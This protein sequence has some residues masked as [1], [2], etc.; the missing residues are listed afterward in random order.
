MLSHPLSLIINFKNLKEKKKAGHKRLLRGGSFTSSSTR[1]SLSSPFPPLPLTPL[2]LDRRC[3]LDPR[4]VVY[5][6]PGALG[7]PQAFVTI[8]ELTSPS[9]TLVTSADLSGSPGCCVTPPRA[10]VTS[11]L[12]FASPKLNRYSLKVLSPSPVPFSVSGFPSQE[13][14][15]LA[16]SLSVPFLYMSSITRSL[17][18]PFLCCDWSRSVLLPR[19]SE[20]PSSPP[21]HTVIASQHGLAISPPVC[22]SSTLP[23]VATSYLS[24]LHFKFLYGFSQCLEDHRFSG[25]QDPG[26]CPP[27]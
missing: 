5:S 18:A 19:P 15:R 3:C 7:C 14:P 2:L 27:L 6:L 13:A 22:L 1:L 4:I 10:S 9:P 16:S 24:L 25:P 12:S 26:P 20:P 11:R 8:C 23:G 21:W 17:S